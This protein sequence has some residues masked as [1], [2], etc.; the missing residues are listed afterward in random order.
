MRHFGSLLLHEA[1]A[2]I[3]H[4]DWS[5]WIGGHIPCCA[6]RGLVAPVSRWRFLHIDRGVKPPAR[7]RR[8]QTMLPAQNTIAAEFMLHAL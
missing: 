4:R 6:T 3:S 8:H 1:Q 5:T 2:R 7:R